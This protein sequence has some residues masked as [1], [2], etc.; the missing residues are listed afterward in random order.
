MGRGEVVG[1]LRDQRKGNK[2]PLT[3]LTSFALVSAQLLPLSELWLEA[4]NPTPQFAEALSSP[5]SWLLGL[6]TE[7]MV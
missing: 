4:H 2:I 5:R 1:S 3:P 6:N 7:Y